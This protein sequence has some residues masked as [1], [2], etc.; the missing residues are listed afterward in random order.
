MAKII[1]IISYM[2]LFQLSLDF[3]A[4]VSFGEKSIFKR[5]QPTMIEVK[6]DENLHW[7]YDNKIARPKADTI[8]PLAPAIGLV[9][10][11]RIQ[12]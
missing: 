1:R 12:G 6:V 3:S 9:K 7:D 11:F 2:I 5:F 8:L 10:T 4:S